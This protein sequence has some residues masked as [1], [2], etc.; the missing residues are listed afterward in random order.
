MWYVIKEDELYHHGIK[1]QKWGV[2]RFQNKDGSL[3]NAGKKRYMEADPNDSAVTKRVKEDYNKLSDSQFRKKYG[4]TKEIYAKR[5]KRYGDPYM[6]APMAKLGKKL[7][8]ISKIEKQSGKS[9]E[10]VA[11]VKKAEREAAKRMMERQK[12][13]A[14]TAVGLA[15]T[16]YS[17]AG[18]LSLYSANNAEIK[19]AV[20]SFV[21]SYKNRKVD[22]FNKKYGE[23]VWTDFGVTDIVSA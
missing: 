14:G 1:G 9:F 8:G 4:A 22:A 19:G 5:V 3:T 18:L 2:R 6:N 16:A 17:V 10:T 21:S 20:N 11:Q 13:I 23:P 7:S 15:I 12:K